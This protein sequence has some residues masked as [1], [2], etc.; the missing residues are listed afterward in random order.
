MGRMT[1]ETRIALVVCALAASVAPP[2]PPPC[3]AQTPPGFVTSERAVVADGVIVRLEYTM[4]DDAGTV[5]DASADGE[6]L[7]FTQGRHQR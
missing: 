7:V 2:G 3:S 4:R 5:L 1:R 6:A